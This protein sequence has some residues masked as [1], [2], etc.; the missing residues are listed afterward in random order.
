[1]KESFL[2][3][4]CIYSMNMPLAA[5]I[6]ADMTPSMFSK[7]V[8]MGLT[9]QLSSFPIFRAVTAAKPSRRVMRM[10]ASIIFSAENCV[11]GGI[12]YTPPRL[13]FIIR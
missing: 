6:V 2:Y 11:F 4:D 9:E 1:M 13:V 8:N 12:A 3:G 5:F 10:A 7:A